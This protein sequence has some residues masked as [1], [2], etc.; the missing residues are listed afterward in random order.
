[1]ERGGDNCDENVDYPYLAMLKNPYRSY[2]GSQVF[3]PPVSL[4]SASGFAQIHSHSNYPGPNTTTAMVRS[5]SAANQDGHSS[6]SSIRESGKT[7]QK[8][9]KVAKYEA[10]KVGEEGYLVNLWVSYH[11]RL[12]SKAS[13][14]YWSKIVE[15]LNAQLNYNRTVEKCK[16]KMKYLVDRYKECKDWNRKQSSGS[17]W[18]PPHYSEIDAVLGVE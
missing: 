13:R 5:E 18:K 10:F 14:K 16:R 2:Y 8:G 12:E 1:M 17:I 4:P 3:W 6:S 7:N 9:K 11:E 15:E